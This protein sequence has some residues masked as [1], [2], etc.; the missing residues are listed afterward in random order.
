MVKTITAAGMTFAGGAN[1]D[2]T[3]SSITLTNTSGSPWAWTS[4]GTFTPGTS[5]ITLTGNAQVTF[6][7][8]GKTYNNVAY[9][10]NNTFLITGANT[11]NDF[12]LIPAVASVNMFLPQANQTITGTLT[13]QGTDS[14]ASGG[15][16]L[17]TLGTNPGNTSQITLTAAA[18]SLRNVDFMNIAAAGASIPW[19]GSAMPDG[20]SSLGDGGGNTG[21]TFDASRTL[22][23]VGTASGWNALAKWS[24]SSGGVTGSVHYPRVH[25]DVIFDAN[26]ITAAGGSIG[27]I[28]MLGRNIDFSGAANT[29]TLSNG[30]SPSV[31]FG[32]VTLKTGMTIT[33][34]GQFQF[35]GRGTHIIKSNGVV[36][37]NSSTTA[38]QI[39]AVGGSYSLSDDLTISN[40]T[41]GLF[42]QAGTFDANGFNLNMPLFSS[43]NS[44][45]RTINGGSGTW[46]ITGT[47]TIW[48]TSTTAGLTFSFGSTT[49]LCTDVSST[50]KT[51][52]CRNTIG[53]LTFA[54]GGVSSTITFDPGATYQTLTLGAPKTYKLATT[55]TTT[56]NT[57]NA[58]GSSGN[59]ITITSATGG[60]PAA[61]I[62]GGSVP[63]Y[64]DWLSLQDIAL[65]GS[66]GYAGDNSTNVSGNT[67]WVFSPNKLFMEGNSMQ[68][69]KRGV[70]IWP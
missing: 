62:N 67:G 25:D 43:A 12:N 28:R 27:V 32:S 41:S 23:W 10:G 13:M 42:L 38:M 22:Y 15:R 37:A 20:N 61:L 35:N 4:T 14:G 31:F 1:V 49:V 47:G 63:W 29:F 58:T 59:L 66:G 48:N 36:W 40:A 7:G 26:S 70:K 9:T 3:T 24:A 33:G 6:A 30:L 56:V 68:G 5:T 46:R 21:I 19:T 69:M 54:G 11:F 55:S 51:F 44:N 45:T 39:A 18:V 57:L 8:G 65:T 50:A 34:V 16:I 60:T 64:C 53:I 17:C 52:A 2:L